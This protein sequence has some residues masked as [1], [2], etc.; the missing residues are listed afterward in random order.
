MVKNMRNI[1]KKSID[2]YK[3]SAVVYARTSPNE[4]AEKITTALTA[5]V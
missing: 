3:N 2:I 4:A 5:D 1:V